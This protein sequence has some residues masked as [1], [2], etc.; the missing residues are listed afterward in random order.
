[1]SGE[2]SKHVPLADESDD[3]S[4]EL[5]ILQPECSIR[6]YSDTLKA[7]SDFLQFTTERGHKKISE[8]LSVLEDVKLKQ[9]CRQTDFI[10][11]FNSSV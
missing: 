9:T 8:V 4:E 5:D 6:T 3:S 10:Q 11:F 2:M 7:A 1:M